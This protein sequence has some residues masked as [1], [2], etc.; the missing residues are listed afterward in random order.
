MLAR[1][2]TRIERHPDELLPVFR[3]LHASYANVKRLRDVD[4]KLASH[5]LDTILHKVHCLQRLPAESVPVSY[6]MWSTHL[7]RIYNCCQKERESLR[8]TYAKWV[9]LETPGASASSGDRHS[10]MEEHQQPQPQPHAT[11]DDALL[12]PWIT[13]WTDETLQA[14]AVK[15]LV[16]RIA[17][18]IMYPD[19]LMSDMGTNTHSHTLLVHGAPNTG[20]SYAVQA[21][22]QYLRQH[23]R[24]SSSS[25]AAMPPTSPTTPPPHANMSVRWVVLS[26]YD[27]PQYARSVLDRERDSMSSP[28]LESPYPQ[29][30]TIYVA[31]RVT[32]SQL[33]EWCKEP[34]YTA[35]DRHLRRTKRTLWVVLATMHEPLLPHSQAAHAELFP[36]R[37]HFEL[38]DSKAVYHYL[39]KRIYDHYGTAAIT[40]TE[41]ATT[42]T[43]GGGGRTFPRFARLPV[44]EKLP[45]LATLMDTYVTERRPDYEEVEHLFETAVSRCSD[46]T[47]NENALL[48]VAADHTSAAT[49]A[50]ATTIWY[51]KNAVHIDKLP[52]HYEYKLLRHSK[53]DSIEWCP[54]TVD[55]EHRQCSAAGG[56][57]TFWNIQLF[58]T[59]PSCEYDRFTHIYIDPKT[60][61]ARQ[62]HQGQPHGQQGAGD[63]AYSVIATFPVRSNIFPYHLRRGLQ[64]CYE[65]A[66]A[67]GCAVSD[68]MQRHNQ[69]DGAERLE[70]CVCTTDVQSLTDAQC[71]ERFGHVQATAPHLN[72]ANANTNT[73]AT[74]ELSQV[75]YI[76]RLRPSASAHPADEPCYHVEYGDKRSSQLS[77]YAS[78]IPYDVSA[79]TL[80]QIVSVLL[81]RKDTADVCSVVQVQTH[82]GY[83]YYIDFV[84]PLERAFRLVQVDSTCHAVV[85]PQV[86]LPLL[87][88]GFD[89]DAN[90]RMT[91][92]SDVDALV[93]KFPHDYKDLYRE[94]E[95][96]WKL[97]PLRAPAHIDYLNEKYT[98]EQKC[99]LQ[100]CS[101]LW[102]AKETHYACLSAATRMVLDDA[103][104]DLQNQ[105]DYLL[106]IIPEN[107]HEGKWNE[108]WSMNDSHPHHA[109]FHPP[110]HDDVDAVT[111]LNLPSAWLRKDASFTV[112]PRWLQVL[113]VVCSLFSDPA[114]PPSPQSESHSPSPSP[115]PSGS[116]LPEIVQTW[117]A[118]RSKD[119][120]TSVHWVYVK[121]TVSHA[122]WNTAISATKLHEHVYGHT[123]QQQHLS[124][125]NKAKHTADLRT[126]STRTRTKSLFH[127]I[128]RR[129][130]HIGYYHVPSNTIRWHTFN[131]FAADD[132]L[133][134]TL[135]AL[136]KEPQLWTLLNQHLPSEYRP[137]LFALQQLTT[138]TTTTHAAAASTAY[139][140][141]YQEL[142]SHLLYP[143]EVSYWSLRTW[144]ASQ[145]NLLADIQH[146]GILDNIVR[147]FAY[148]HKHLYRRPLALNGALPGEQLRKAIELTRTVSTLPM[149]SRNEKQLL[150]KDD[151]KR[152]RLYGLDIHHLEDSLLTLQAH[153]THAHAH[154]HA[155]HPQ[156]APDPTS[157]HSLA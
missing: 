81:N 88:H 116:G 34:W 64:G 45:E 145:R 30:W 19:T 8:Q 121:S 3:E 110:N 53:H 92:E 128:M 83:A 41:T 59:L 7:T 38:P 124:S 10:Q 55:G 79:D 43:T 146:Q 29:Q 20:K 151:L 2:Q 149:A 140:Y 49:T 52:A 153:H 65:W 105:L 138:S 157:R 48:G 63:D 67:F 1:L 137:W 15:R 14:V 89:L 57:T 25:S 132:P 115:S 61:P 126:Y 118:Y 95:A 114:Q 87:Q 68:A 98:N 27:C 127:E 139:G 80:H 39:K 156:A 6:D 56:A 40:E 142:Y 74:T 144:N 4:M 123:M 76:E 154:A 103:L 148:I 117:K 58:D 143:P 17:L 91:T 94:D 130:D 73:N 129:S 47:L 136:H 51:P 120:Q 84:V 35:W 93:E 152:I 78:G 50:A 85:L 77:D 75:W 99:Y 46:C 86:S 36:H 62:N 69:P 111:H 101:D 13:D 131:R 134:P 100:L 22:R 82:S 26:A 23:R 5:M 133:G 33:E 70:A 24:S 90:Y 106:Q 71:R 44:V 21:I 54:Q 18:P 155:H 150:S 66:T 112:S 9:K 104:A 102:R 147:Q 28:P 96:T 37:Y 12:S 16:R 11:A 32:R 109:L 113:A 125:S 42:T 107:D 31:D 119:V 108:V 60:I 122:F 72:F 97:K 141:T 135:A